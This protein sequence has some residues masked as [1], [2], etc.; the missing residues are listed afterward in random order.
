MV[1]VTDRMVEAFGDAWNAKR[2]ETASV[3]AAPGTKTRAG[4]EAALRARSATTPSIP[5]IQERLAKAALD[6]LELGWLSDLAFEHSLNYEPDEGL[7]EVAGCY[8][9]VNQLAYV[10][11]NMIRE[12]Q[13]E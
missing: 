11:Q 13:G 1:E 10:V 9:D 7:I 12:A 8:I 4:L 3:G 6:D 5:Q 2:I